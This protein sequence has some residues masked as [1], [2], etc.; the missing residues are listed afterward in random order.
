MGSFT[1]NGPRRVPRR[2]ARWRSRTGN[3]NSAGGLIQ[4][5]H[6]PLGDHDDDQT[7]QSHEQ[8]A[9]RAHRRLARDRH[10]PHPRR[11]GAATVRRPGP[12]TTGLDAT[13][14]GTKSNATVGA[15]LSAA[16][17]GATIDAERRDVLHRHE[18]RLASAA[19][20]TL[21]KTLDVGSKITRLHGP[22]QR[23]EREPGGNVTKNEARSPWRANNTSGDVI[24]WT[25]TVPSPFTVSSGGILVVFAVNADDTT[26]ISSSKTNSLNCTESRARRRRPL[27]ARPR[28]ARLR[29]PRPARLR[30][31]RRRPRR[32]A[33]GDPDR[34]PAEHA[35]VDPDVDPA[36]HPAL[37]PAEHAAVD[38]ALDPAEHAAVD[39]RRRPRRAP[40]PRPRRDAAVDPARDPAEHAAQHPAERDSPVSSRAAASSRSG[41]APPR[42]TGGVEGATGTPGVT[43]PPTDTL[44]ATTTPSSDG[45][46]VVFIGLAAILAAT[47]AFTTPRTGD[48][49]TADHSLSLSEPETG[50]GSAPG[51]FMS[52][53]RVPPGARSVA[54]SIRVRSMTSPGSTRR[55]GPSIAALTIRG[56]RDRVEAHLEV[57]QQDPAGARRPDA[58][59]AIAGA[60]RWMRAG[61]H[62][63][64]RRT[65]PRRAAC[66]RAGSAGARSVGARRSRPSRRGPPASM[67]EPRTAWLSS[68]WVTRRASS[69]RSPIANGP[70]RSMRSTSSAAAV[71]PGSVVER[72][73][74]ARQPGRRDDPRPAAAG[75]NW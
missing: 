62:R 17:G 22:E 14:N 71:N 42:P 18:R 34:D 15:S 20:F 57:G 54:G 74:P 41:A 56:G 5:I 6:A 53:A 39:A 7:N 33:A 31:P 45:W 51:L 60:S 75:R 21:S 69:V 36:E 64:R 23:L 65:T 61:R 16:G 55:T 73:E 8:R 72:V 10:P 26:A 27:T 1:A 3:G 30:R 24:D 19:T 49:A 25:I 46:R 59:S 13:G 2:R 28:R 67:R 38:P 68:V 48:Q 9:R 50:R 4:F 47:L 37:D 66:R 52:G 70:G 29:R 12:A 58:S 40:R 32:H 63:A 44:G 11:A 35:A 43:P